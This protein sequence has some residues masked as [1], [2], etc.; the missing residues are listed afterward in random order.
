MKTLTKFA[1][2]LVFGLGCEIVEPECQRMCKPNGVKR[3]VD[4]PN[5]FEIC[6]C[7]NGTSEVKLAHPPTPEEGKPVAPLTEAVKEEVSNAVDELE[8]AIKEMNP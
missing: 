1:L 8:A 6:V 5:A 3:Y 7:V 2:F 4:V